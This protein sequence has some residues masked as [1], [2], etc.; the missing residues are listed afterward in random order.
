[1][2]P[3]M[4]SR[5]DAS[6]M[7]QD[8]EPLEHRICEAQ[9]CLRMI[10]VDSLANGQ[11]SLV[12]S[13]SPSLRARARSVLTPGKM[14]VTILYP[15]A[16]A[17]S[18]Q[19]SQAESKAGPPAQTLHQTTFEAERSPSLDP[20]GMSTAD[21]GGYRHE[22]PESCDL[23]VHWRPQSFPPDCATCQVVEACQLR[24]LHQ[25]SFPPNCG[26]CPM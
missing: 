10:F 23:C 12:T 14:W 22:C 4:Q 18:S 2:K 8:I 21:V 17:P 20:C 24:L 7:R 15:T 11:R 9:S 13:L 25:Q 6:F 3:K 1:M 19:N 26:T 5:A 16:F